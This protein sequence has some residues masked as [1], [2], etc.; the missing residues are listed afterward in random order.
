[1]DESGLIAADLGD[2]CTFHRG[3]HDAATEERLFESTVPVAPLALGGA[4]YRRRVA[5]FVAKMDG[6]DDH[7]TWGENVIGL[8]SYAATD[9]VIRQVFVTSEDPTAARR[10]RSLDDEQTALAWV[11]GRTG[12]PIVTVPDHGTLQPQLRLHFSTSDMEVKIT[13]ENEEL[14]LEGAPA[15]F[16]LKPRPVAPIAGAWRVATAVA[17][18]WAQ[19]V[20]GQSREC[21]EYC[22]RG[23][24]G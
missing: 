5:A 17:A 22:V 11:G 9:R 12:A 4:R 13:L 14:V 19:G 8:V 20:Q 2:C 23:N 24:R 18:P 7:G 1:L 15:G 3:Y 21:Q 16:A 10:L 6:N